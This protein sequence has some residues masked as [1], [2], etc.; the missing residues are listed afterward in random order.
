MFG[1]L[2]HVDQ[3]GY[4]FSSRVKQFL[5]TNPSFQKLK[6]VLKP[7]YMKKYASVLFALEISDDSDSEDST[8]TARSPPPP[9]PTPR[10]R[11]LDR[12]KAL[13]E[14]KKSVP[15][16]SPSGKER[17]KALS[18][19]KK[20]VPPSSGIPKT[21]QPKPPHCE[22]DIVNLISPIQPTRKSKRTPTAKKK[23]L[24]ITPF[25]VFFRHDNCKS[26]VSHSSVIHCTDY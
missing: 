17:Q 9:S 3:D 13:P 16:S 23:I 26:F 2:T 18:E 8:S 5:N 14:K 21:P 15:P 7:K 1:V 25:K 12:Q 6:R 22:G 11:K 4:D 20:S 19:K 10:K 24:D